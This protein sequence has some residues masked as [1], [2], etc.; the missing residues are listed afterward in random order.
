MN[1]QF[2]SLCTDV[3]AGNTMFRIVVKSNL[4]QSLAENLADKIENIV[5][6]LDEMDG[7]YES[8]HSKLTDLAIAKEEEEEDQL[9]ELSDMMGLPMRNSSSMNQVQ[10]SFRKKKQKRT[11]VLAQNIC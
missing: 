8:I 9:K 2:E 7:G 11:S 10:R 1:E 6:V 4:T 5:S 3:T